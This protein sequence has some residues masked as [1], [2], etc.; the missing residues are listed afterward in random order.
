LVIANHNSPK[1]VVLSGTVDAVSE[2]EQR[3]AAERIK[4]KRLPVGTA[5]HSPLVSSSSAP[6]REFLDEIKMTTPGMDSYSNA[7]AAPYPSTPTAIR[8]RLAEQ[9]ASP[10]RFVEQVE[11]MYEAGARIFLEVGPGAVLTGLVG[12]CLGKRSFQAVS[13]DRKGRHGITS[14]WHALGQLATAGQALNF[15]ALWQEFQPTA[16]PRT[17][18]KPKM[19]LN[20][21][22]S[23]YD[24]P[25]PPPGGAADL[26]APNPP[27]PVTPPQASPPA[28]EKAALEQAT[29]A[30]R[31]SP[32]SPP[33][34]QVATPAPVQAGPAQAAPAQAGPVQAAPQPVAA[35]GNPTY[36]AWLGVY[37][38]AQ[39]QTVEAH[40]A[41]QQNMATSQ[42]A[43][44]QTIEASFAGLRQL[45]GGPT[46]QPSSAAVP[47]PQPVVL[48][49]QQPSALQQ[50]SPQQPAKT[51]GGASPTGEP[52][53]IPAP[54][55]APITAVPVTAPAPVPA[56]GPDLASL[57]QL[58]IT[59]VAEKTGYPEEMLQL[60]MDM[61]ADLGIDSI[62][63]V[64]ILAAMRERAPELPEV[65]T[66]QMA[67]LRT[68]QQIVDYMGQ[69]AAEVA[70]TPAAPTLATPA[71]EAAAAARSIPDGTAGNGPDMD[72]LRQLMLDVVAEKTGYP[73]DMLQLDMDMEADL[74]I[75]S[76]KRVEILAAMRER[77]PELP[78]VDTGQMAVL[79]TLQQIVD[80]MGQEKTDGEAAPSAPQASAVESAVPQAKRYALRTVVT[81][82]AGLALPGLATAK[83]LL[84]TDDGGGVAAAL[85]T[86]LA[87]WGLQA[88]VVQEDGISAAGDTDG[89]I[90]LDGLR[91]EVDLDAALAI[92]RS[93]FSAAHT[94]AKH[95]TEH[96]GVFVT[97]QDTGG[98]FG[99]SGQSGPRA[100]LGAL[101]GL[102]KT[103]AQEWPR[104]GVKAIDLER[105]GR[106]AKEL[107]AALARELLHGGPELEVGLQADGK[108]QALESYPAPLQES[109]GTA[110]PA[111][112]GGVVVATGG[113]RG[114]TA[115]T[116][117][118]LA[119]DA[120]GRGAPP[121]LVLL[122]RTALAEEPD[123]CADAISEAD[124]K[125][126]LLDVAR[127]A[128]EMPKPKELGAQ[129]S[130]ILAARE[131][132]GTVAALAEV[133]AEARYLPV[134][135]RNREDL[136][137]ALDS[138]RQDWGPITGLVHGAGVI[139]DR[140]IADKTLEQVDRVIGTKV[141]GLRHLLA[142][143]SEDPLTLICLF[144]SVTAR[145]GNRG[146][147][148]YAMA[149]EILNKIAAAEAHRR[150]GACRVKS[151]GWGPW[152]GGM[153]TPALE[154][155]FAAQGVPLI[156]LEEGARMLVEE[157]QGPDAT[158][159]EL[160]LG[161]E[162]RPTPLLDN[163]EE[164]TRRFDAFV[165]KRSHAYLE[166]HTIEGSVVFPVVLGLEWLGRIAKAHRPDLELRSLS[167]LAVLRGIQLADFTGKGEAFQLES[168]LKSNGSGCVLALELR[169]REDRPRYR[170][171]AEMA[172][173]IAAPP[174]PQAP[175]TGLRPWPELTV[176]GDVLFHGPSFQ[177]I[178]QLGGISAEGMAATLQGTLHKKWEKS[179][180]ESQ[181]LTDPAALDGGLQLAVLWFKN[182]L[183]GASL[184]LSIGT[185]TSYGSGLL[186]GP[187]DAVLHSE[188]RDKNRAVATIVFS[189]G[190]T[191]VAELEGV[192]IIR[193]PAASQAARD[194]KSDPLTQGSTELLN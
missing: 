11:A 165:S 67:V 40:T 82:P 129:A 26:P 108:R 2:A 113:A 12:K 110:T 170:A 141:D 155:R 53:S 8:R 190:G 17:L 51:A 102:V 68:L 121:R 34:P 78:E 91:P 30:A 180:E 74:G 31:T 50:P 85:V 159:V 76:I 168:T 174:T 71:P 178:Q 185:Y 147:A 16:D 98:D 126:A 83:R 65:D 6:F 105:G 162:P 23:N 163:G 20:I 49:A 127:Q 109:L 142:A 3:L 161:G 103:A 173:S 52:S 21:N 138:V 56:A 136:A 92:G 148:D 106:T 186:E 143:T 134:D 176:Y 135:V 114:V 122:G 125:R 140:F 29:P 112:Q 84:L 38:E 175:L 189:Q 131:V 88:E 58:M 35:S 119:R 46:V 150:G 184:P 61:E 117:I 133:G 10:V 42:T 132:R 33:A 59:V 57:R 5:F 128:G 144:S 48:S 104:A 137:T 152:K 45:L 19:V 151:L 100:A 90:F 64:E 194:P 25:Y 191:V 41:F 55:P 27:R 139:E 72:S 36:Q 153:V 149:N 115:A 94:V 37:Q 89:L 188:T 172:P 167:K 99:L 192:E 1:Q 18:P 87:T 95:F 75:D 79:R 96:G 66:G 22:G 81:P 24:K 28:F 177:V 14:L 60:D 171:T 193:R 156:A 32:V 69:G 77:A 15:S 116:L 123:G 164:D 111:V 43:F 145:C 44:L 62:K 7:K 130:R 124:L 93:A 183:G 157:V 39:R 86:E 160:V 4:A 181:W 54:T 80:Y 166:G 13:L 169:D 9:I 73:T 182:Q 47:A 158:S 118:A 146:Q 120:A 63:R 97:V 154:A 107:A 187:I 70:P 179:G 101:A